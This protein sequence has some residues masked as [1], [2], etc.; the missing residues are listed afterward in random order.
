MTRIMP[1]KRGLFAFGPGSG[2]SG[3]S[4][5]VLRLLLAA[6]A[7]VFVAIVAAGSLASEARA[8]ST[9]RLGDV[10]SGTLL[11]R[12]D[13]AGAYLPAPLVKTD[14]HTDV[15]GTIA[16]VT[17]SQ[18]FE[19]PSNGWVEG[20]YAF[21]LPENA[22]VD[23][24]RLQIG[25]RFIEG[26]I[27]ERDEARKIYDQAKA[28]GHKAS[29]IEEQRPN[30]FTNAVANI[31][32]H[33]TVIVQ[34]EYQQTVRYDQGTFA[35]R[36]PLVIGPRYIPGPKL[37]AQAG[38]AIVISDPVPDA[39]KITPPVLHPSMGKVNP[40]TLDVELD[41][42]A[43][44]AWIKSPSHDIAVT[45]GANGRQTVT[46]AKDGNFADR[47]FVLEWQPATGDKPTTGLFSETIGGDGY[48]L[49]T[50]LPP[51][52]PVETVKRLP[53]D[54]TFV[55]DTSG[56][57]SGPSIRQ[58][59]QALHLAL[60]RLSPEDRFNIVR[61][62]STASR[63]FTAPEPAAKAALDRAHGFVDSLEAE[64]GTEM[65]PAL[66]L[67]LAEKT[68]ENRLGQ[69]VFLT[70]G[71]VGNEA[72]LFAFLKSR[73]GATRLFT[74]GIGS[75]PNS[76][77]MTKSAEFGHGTYTYIGR[78]D[79][80]AEKMTALFQKIEEP[81]VTDVA[82]KVAGAGAAEAWPRTLPD[83]YRGEP[84]VVALRLPGAGKEMQTRHGRAHR[85][86]RR[87]ALDRVAAARRRASGEGRRRALGALQDRRAQRRALRGRR[88][89]DGAARGDR[90][91]ARPSSGQRLHQPGRGRRDAE[92][93]GRHQS[94]HDRRA[95]QPAGRLELREGVRRARRACDLA[96]A[97]H[98]VA[99]RTVAAPQGRGD[100]RRRRP[101][102]GHGR[103]ADQQRRQRQH[104]APGRHASIVEADRRI[105][106]HPAR[107][108]APVVVPAADLAGP[109]IPLPPLRDPRV[110]RSSRRLVPWLVLLLLSIG[111]WQAG[112]G[113][114]IYGKAWLAQLLLEDAWRR[115]EVGASGPVR[116]WPWA[117]TWPV[118]RLEVPRL[119][120][121]EIVLAGGSGRTLAFAPG[122]VDG[123]AA[124]GSRGQQHHRRPPRHPFPLPAAT[125]CRATG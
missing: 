57:M 83:L 82:L 85:P 108:G 10:Q 48:L 90:G 12:T 121:D 22:A 24:L 38:N 70:D 79:E 91:G 64:G 44:L 68:P 120:I 21:P 86:P 99:D 92:P 8:A 9:M 11:L 50:V 41:A 66:Q 112:H 98:A 33:E 125:S 60:D 25:E 39:D 37:V 18:R 97:V 95:A 43:P 123:T 2:R 51:V 109:L 72:E 75:A 42:G 23:R 20:V 76:Y 124:P 100:D 88:P 122:H 52:K 40:V 114:F 118:A 115:T 93:A 55:I 84:I 34:I 27:K 53:R 45:P 119:G 3:A 69:I 87:P 117:D 103:P 111:G 47:D 62:S 6:L 16:R 67:A 58:A 104:P 71:S 101:A 73:L 81:V 7:V 107:A 63:L 5:P 49:V 19:N 29:L 105:P 56:S 113:A 74:V 116:P 89:R 65:L 31:G 1:A 32:P 94:H 28:A 36:F 96:A 106:L 59:R 17:V 15:G 30:M 54:V 14:V 78:V 46:F 102:T 4:D 110:M 80:V 61:F 35:L 26:E 77:F 13:D